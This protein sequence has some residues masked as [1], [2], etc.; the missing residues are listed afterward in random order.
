VKA[1]KKEKTATS[2]ISAAPKGK[3]NKVLTHRPR[4]IEKARVSKLVEG[5]PSTVEPGQPAVA[6]SKEESTEVLEI[7]G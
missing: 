7:I 4:Y 6:G 1:G 3:K 5:T 2:A